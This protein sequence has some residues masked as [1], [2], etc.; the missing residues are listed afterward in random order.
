MS[1]ENIRE[2]DHGLVVEESQPETKEPR[3]YKV[4]ILNDDYTPMDFVVNVLRRFFHMD[5]EKATRV[6]LQIH[7]EGQGTAGIFTSDIA[8]TKVSLVNDYARANDHPLMSTMEA[9]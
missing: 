6:M 7:Y 1:N 2:E 8:E 3:M 5:T 9:E 4:L